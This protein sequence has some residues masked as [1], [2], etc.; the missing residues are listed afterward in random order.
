[1]KPFLPY[2]ALLFSFLIGSI[3]TAYLMGRMRGIDIR[4]HGSRN[5]GAT[6]AFRVLGKSWGITCLV[7]DMLKGLIP[8]AF[9]FRI[10]T[11]G[12]SGWSAEG[13]MWTLGLAAIAGH[14]FSPFLNF[15]GGKGVATS[16]GVVLAIAPLPMLIAFALG[17]LIIWRTG[18]V[19]LASMT[20]AS[21]LPILILIFQWRQHPW[22]SVVITVLLAVVIVWKHRANIQRL[23]EG[24]E[25]RIIISGNGRSKTPSGGGLS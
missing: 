11:F 23:R 22:I 8:I 16:L 13:W 21:L 2:L 18:Y 12:F 14:M 17:I 10:H 24:T 4:Q 6:N 19:S 20:G 3:P 9:L 5:V 7:L 1:M 15:K 25:K